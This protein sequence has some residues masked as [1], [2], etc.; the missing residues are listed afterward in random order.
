[1]SFLSILKKIVG[2]EHVLAPIVSI[3]VPGTAPFIAVLDNFVTKISGGVQAAEATIT[4]VGSGIDKSNAVIADFEAGLDLAN[5]SLSLEGEML[6]YD[7][8]LL[9]DA[10]SAFSLAYNKCAALKASVHVVALPKPT[11]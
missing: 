9:Q 8:Q 7:H 2:V 10:I 3:T 11:A 5:A 1:M 4:A 6:D